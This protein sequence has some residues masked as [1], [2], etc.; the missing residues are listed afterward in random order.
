[1]QDINRHPAIYPDPTEVEVDCAE[2]GCGRRFAFGDAW[3]LSGGLTM[4]GYRYVEGYG[5]PCE[6]VACSFEHALSAFT[7]C[8]REHWTHAAHAER[9]AQEKRRRAE[10]G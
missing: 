10:Q 7:R 4:A 5:A 3:K 2:P 6:H 9:V 1:M 8:A